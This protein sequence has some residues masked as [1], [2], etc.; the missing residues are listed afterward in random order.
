MTVDRARLRRTIAVI[1]GKGGVL[2]TTL[3]ANCAGML[4]ASG[5]KVLAVDLDPQGNLAEDLGYDDAPDNDEGQSLAAALMFGSAPSVRRDVRPNL[6]VLVGGPELDSASAGLAAPALTTRKKR[7]PRLALA[8]LLEPLAEDYDLIFLDCP[9]GDEMLQT[10]A[11]AAAK[12]ALVPVKSDKSSRKGLSAVARRLDAAV[13]V[14]PELD[15]LGVVLTDIGSTATAVERE[16]RTNVASLFGFGDVVF[17]A[18]VRHS[19]ATAQAAR[20]RG[21]LVVELEQAAK[22]GPKWWQVL[23][24]DADGSAMVPATAS[25]VAGDLFAVAQEIVDRL[26]VAEAREGEK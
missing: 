5:F 3:V 22:D 18:T 1:N 15:L 26:T 10:N 2:K 11:I 9:P 24:G 16:A 6:D 12:W 14:N 19:E 4:A 13:D 21:K 7:D 8:N 17:S 20:D 25:S 23:K